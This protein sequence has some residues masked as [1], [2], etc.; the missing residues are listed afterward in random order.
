MDTVNTHGTH[1]SLMGADLW[2]TVFGGIILPKTL[3]ELDWSKVKVF[4]M[5]QEADLDI[6]TWT[7]LYVMN[8][9]ALSG[10]LWHKG[11]AE[12]RYG[13]PI[14]HCQRTL[15]A[16]CMAANM[17]LPGSFFILFCFCPYT[18]TP[19]KTSEQ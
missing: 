12:G 15:S 8:V 2:V 13:A 6:C 17:M 1:K 9:L 14:T 3:F 18:V 7:W 11:D 16:V 5:R 19:E 10:S 4:C